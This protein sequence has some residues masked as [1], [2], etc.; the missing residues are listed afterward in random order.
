MIR[1]LYFPSDGKLRT[2]V[3]LHDFKTALHDSGG[4]LW[5]DFQGNPPEEDEP[6]LREVFGF[7]PLAIDDALRESHVPKI[8]DWGEYLYIVLHTV[9]FNRNPE[10]G[11]HLDTLELDIFLGKNYLVTHHDSPIDAIEHAW[12]LTRR[13]DRHLR[14]GSDH[15]LYRIA[16]DV[17]AN[18][19]PVVEAI[20]EAIDTAEDQ[21]FDRPDPNTLEHIFM[22]KRSTLHLR[23]VIGPQ[24][25][26]LNKLAR[27]DYQVIDAKARVYFRDVYDHLVR[28]HDISESI[29][30]L[31]SGALD[32]YLSVINNRM[33]DIMKTLTVIT[34]MFMPI[35]FI[36]SFFGMNFFSPVAP[37]DIWT[38][39]AAF[40]ITMA[41]IILTPV[42]FFLWIRRRG[43]M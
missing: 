24:R 14:Q 32:T 39:E 6:I 17:V 34:T 8:D 9:V 30:D 7:H 1:A 28:L 16:D 29:R 27:D 43:W 15:L 42:A 2:D 25:E 20:D 33:N 13:D 40:I 3:E 36:A 23:R 4:L 41:I 26:V 19:M 31:V 38:G 35:S 18:Y 11:D 21:I 22:L 10:E 37:L 5:V 12:D